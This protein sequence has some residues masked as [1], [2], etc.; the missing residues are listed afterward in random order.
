MDLNYD[1][2]F[3]T[4][5]SAR[6][7]H[8]KE[9]ARA[10]SKGMRF[11]KQN[12]DTEFFLSLAGDGHA[13][14]YNFENDRRKK[15]NFLNTQIIIFDIDFPTT[16]MY[17]YV[18]GLP[19]K[20]T[21]AYTT[22]SNDPG[23][24]YYRFRLVYCFDSPIATVHEFTSIYLAVSTANGFGKTLDAC[25]KE[26]N[27]MFY[28]S[29]D[30]LDGFQD[31]NSHII[32]SR[33]DFQAFLPES[34][35]SS[36]LS[37][38]GI[39]ISD[40]PSFNEDGTY[41]TLTEEE[42]QNFYTNYMESL[43]TPL[44][45]APSG[46]HFTFP[47]GYVKVPIRIGRKGVDRWRDGERRRGKLF[48]SAMIMLH[49]VPTLTP[50]NLSFNLWLLVH[51]YYDNTKDPITKDDIDDITERAFERRSSYKLMPS[52]H[53]GGTR[54][55][56]EYWA[57]LGYSARQAAPKVQKE[58]H[59]EVMKYYDPTLSVVDNFDALLEKGL[60][61]SPRTLYR[62]IEELDLKRDV[63]TEIIE[64]MQKEPTI[65]IDEIASSMKKSTSTIKRHIKRLKEGDHPRVKRIKKQWIV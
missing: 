64:W 9:S 62:Y 7:F 28:G 53:K 51:T 40:F 54:V 63:D 57:K 4:S 20:P 49:N 14:C 31:Y 12:L 24:Q 3:T 6:S 23:I 45:L 55:N 34:C 50:D 2:S 13:F 37:A 43:E 19:F 61:V 16:D 27:Q 52:Y 36:P 30:R 35:E 46:T 44:D 5:V 18:Q 47:E 25:S 15:E 17:T 56:K 21:M 41:E 42:R 11:R 48:I 29:D 1:Y 10:G 32:Y 59:Q 39:T 26:W 60:A 22:Y 65:T 58:L 33:D 8:D 38:N